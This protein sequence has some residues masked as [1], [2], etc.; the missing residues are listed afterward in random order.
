LSPGVGGQAGRRAPLAERQAPAK[1]EQSVKEFRFA[2]RLPVPLVALLLVL[3]ARAETDDCA[4]ASCTAGA[5]QEESPFL[6]FGRLLS[7]PGVHDRVR[8]RY[9]PIV[10]QYPDAASCLEGGLPPG[11]DIRTR[12]LRWH[13][14]QSEEEVNVCL[15]RVLSRISGIDD[16]RGWL[17]GEGFEHPSSYNRSGTP[18]SFNQAEGVSI[19]KFYVRWKTERKGAPYGNDEV[20]QKLEH[21]TRSMDIFVT[22]AES[23]GLVSVLARG[24]SK[25]AK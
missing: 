3:A 6:W 7:D 21:L 17:L 24:N 18:N 19:I 8:T 14:L 5:A 23:V 22:Y 9:V 12:H 4:G 2:M 10:A 25:W 20:R 13:E 16:I 15:F 11:A 1:V